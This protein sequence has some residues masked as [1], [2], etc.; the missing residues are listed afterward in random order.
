MF[1]MYS[2][3][4]GRLPILN[5]LPGYRLDAATADVLAGLTVGMTVIPQVGTTVGLIDIILPDGKRTCK[6]Q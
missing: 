6:H 4:S 5:W 2:V 3:L 1:C